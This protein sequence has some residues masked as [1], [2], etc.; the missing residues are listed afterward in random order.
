MK[1]KSSKKDFFMLLI[2]IIGLLSVLLILHVLGI[3]ES[4]CKTI[5]LA[6]EKTLNP[7]LMEVDL[8]EGWSRNIAIRKEYVI[9]QKP[10]PRGSI[11]IR[12]EI[13]DRRPEK[14]KNLRE[15]VAWEVVAHHDQFVSEGNLC[16]L[17]EDA[18]KMLGILEPRGVKGIFYK[19]GF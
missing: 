18:T 5:G 15:L 14:Q 8:D 2:V 13:I 11:F 1:E 19:L 10:G 3:T 7:L 16:R 4:F 6:Q 9:F 17:T 12:W